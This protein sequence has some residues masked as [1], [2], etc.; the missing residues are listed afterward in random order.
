MANAATLGPKH[1]RF[2]WSSIK[3]D[4]RTDRDWPS[5]GTSRSRPNKPNRTPLRSKLAVAVVEPTLQIL[6]V[7]GHG[8]DVLCPRS[9]DHALPSSML[10]IPNVHVTMLATDDGWGGHSSIRWR[11]P[12]ASTNLEDF[13]NL[14]APMPLGNPLVD[15]PTNVSC[16]L[17]HW[18][19]INGMRPCASRRDDACRD[20]LFL[21]KGKLNGLILRDSR[22]GCRQLLRQTIAL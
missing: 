13:S 19:G 11:A 20:R 2:A 14:R 6:T 9:I 3:L 16:R 5:M 4:M 8:W 22:P 17:A 15:H 12:L 7:V 18:E 1:R 21:H 10:G